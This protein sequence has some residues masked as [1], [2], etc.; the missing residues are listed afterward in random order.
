MGNPV[1]LDL[2]RGEASPKL[3]NVGVSVVIPTRNRPHDLE[4]AVASVLEQGIEC[5]VIVVDDG[6][7]PP[8]R[9]EGALMDDAVQII[10]NHAALGP[11]RSRA[12]GIAQAS[13]SFIAFLDDDDIWLPGKLARSLRVTTEIPDVQVVVHRTGFDM[14]QVDGV[15]SKARIE[16]DPLHFYGR[17][18]TPHLNS[19]LVD[20][21]LARAVGF[22]EAF[23]ACS[24]IDFVIGLARRTPFAMIDDVLALRGKDTASSEI[25]IESRIEGRQLLKAKHR[26]VFSSDAKSKAFQQVRMAHLHRR[27]GHRFKA[28]LCFLEALLHRPTYKDA[29]Y[30][31]G[32]TI[33]PPETGKNL[34]I[35]RRLKS[36]PDGVLSTAPLVEESPATGLK[37]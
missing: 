6:S 33:L 13:G 1:F 2:R 4:L 15:P 24:D 32:I 11:C 10:R 22:D 30:G 7:I 28:L 31:A 12:R 21:D 9:R 36:A 18:R 14:R 37:P 20:A 17:T 25:A 35:R 5:E 27:A 29:W 34:S 26:D 3:R 8:V 19:V 23:Y 16:S